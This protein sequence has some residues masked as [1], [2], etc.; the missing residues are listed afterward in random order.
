[1]K[2]SGLLLGMGTLLA[3]SVS[4]ATAQTS[5]W[6]YQPGQGPR[7]ATAT[8]SYF[9]ADTGLP[10]GATQPARRPAH[11]APAPVKTTASTGSVAAP[12]TETGLDLGVQVS[13][14]RY[15]ERELD[16]SMEGP[17][18]GVTLDGTYALSGVGFVRGET[19]YSYGSVD[20]K[21][22]GKK[23]GLNDHL[24]EARAE[25]GHDFVWNRFVLSPYA[26]IGY[27]Y[28]FNNFAVT[29]STGAS[30]YDRVSQYLFAPVGVQPRLKLGNGATLSA[31]LEY[32]PLLKGWQESRFSTMTS[33]YPDVTN[34]QDSGYGLRGQF[35][36]SQARW[37]AGPFV[38]YWNLGRSSYD[39]ATASVTECGYEPH[40][41]T[42]EY[43]L[44][45]TYRLF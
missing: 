19:R 23:S 13:G 27:R 4:P 25:L 45:L 7:P 28:L 20:Y 1:M 33:G 2:T 41:H 14:Y 17:R 3:L 10:A 12:V 11:A 40:N 16:M 15:Y 9:D 8:S 29:T 38:N 43:G 26:G 32:D 36:Y 42:V 44:R 5:R 34:D 22:T 37:A 18:G 30:G 6:D 31:L 39:C 24:F 21:G 35:L